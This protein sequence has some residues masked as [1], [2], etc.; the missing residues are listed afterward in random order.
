M[1]AMAI[2][3]YMAGKD[4][5]ASNFLKLCAKINYLP[6]FGEEL[7]KAWLLHA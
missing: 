2:A 7:E 6:E 4:V 3:K 1:F 5:E